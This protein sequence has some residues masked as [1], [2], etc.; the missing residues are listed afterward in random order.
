MAFL[1]EHLELFF[2]SPTWWR[3][4]LSLLLFNYARTITSRPPFYRG[5]LAIP[6]VLGLRELLLAFYPSHEVLL[7]GESLILAL[8]IGWLGAYRGETK[9]PAL[10]ALLAAA[11]VISLVLRAVL[12]RA[13]ALVFL[14]YVILLSLLILFLFRLEHISALNTHGGEFIERIR[15]TLDTLYPAAVVLIAIVPYETL[16]SKMIVLPA[17]FGIHYF[18]LRSYRRE[19]ERQAS[20]D[21]AQMHKYLNSTFDFMR[22][23]N[24]ALSERTAIQQVIDY[25]TDAVIDSTGADGGAVLLVNSEQE[26]LEVQSLKGY[27]PPPYRVPEITKKRV[28]KVQVY[29]RST[30]IPLGQTVLG[31]AAQSRSPLFV[32]DSRHDSRLAEQNRDHYSYAS[33]LIVLPLIASQRL[34]GVLT[35][36]MRSPERLFTSQD[37]QRCTIFADYTALTIEAMYNYTEIL[38]KR[39]I[40]REVNI[41][42]DIQRHL[43]PE[44][45]PPLPGMDIAAGS[46]P[47]RGV[48]GD[49]YDLI[50][51]SDS[52]RIGLLMCDVAGKG[53]PA[54]LV[55]VMIRTVIHLLAPEAQSAAHAVSMINRGV[56]GQV[57][58]ERFATLSYLLLDPKKGEVEYCNAAHHPL[59]VYRAADESFDT[60]D[61]GGLPVGID[62]DA[63]FLPTTLKLRHGDLL[64]LCTDGITEA[65]DPEANQ[66]GETRLRETI[67][68][69]IEKRETCEEIRDRLFSEVEE[70]A[71]EQPQHDDQTLIVLRRE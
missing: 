51:F 50:T 46:K 4:L 60:F 69:G 42:A 62:A 59:L 17:S 31:K 36:A 52:P 8:Y 57:G 54:S 63:E 25:V 68:D 13:G 24:E 7:L 64:L 56:A 27:Y 28:G 39:E 37:F 11:A 45:L 35:V 16:I 6:A 9:A 22:T 12:D 26:E 70:F 43:Q 29:F 67:L 23:I 48:G 44:E 49:Y 55:M 40:E 19:A 14:E 65:M 3:F 21:L 34:F 15:S 1:A 5:L 38:E 61:T 32:R 53:I 2:S 10:S 66:F 18:L 58:I 41:A 71:G 20:M 33:S 30:P 47:A